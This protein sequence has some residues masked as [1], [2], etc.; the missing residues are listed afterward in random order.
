[1]GLLIDSRPILQDKSLEQIEELYYSRQSAY[2][3]HNS[4][5]VRDGSLS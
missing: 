2:S 5:V 4:E 3:H 1:M